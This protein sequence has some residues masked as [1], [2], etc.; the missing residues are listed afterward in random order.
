[1]S[2]TARM[3][4]VIDDLVPSVVGTWNVT[5]PTDSSSSLPASLTALQIVY[6]APGVS[7]DQIFGSMSSTP[8][9]ITSYALMNGKITRLGDGSLFVSFVLC[10]DSKD[11]EFEGLLLSER[12]MLGE[13]PTVQS[14]TF[15]AG[16]GSW[17]AQ[18]QG[19]G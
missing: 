17:S 14:G 18:A 15:D 3:Q 16:D 8:P 6:Q 11:Y 12:S 13:E 19:G 1:M 5:W 10:I 2:T 9:D 7:F 4:E